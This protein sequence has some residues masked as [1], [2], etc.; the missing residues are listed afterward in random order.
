M[1]YYLHYES[2]SEGTGLL[3][4]ERWDGEKWFNETSKKSKHISKEREK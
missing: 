4:K 3:F 1:L 2:I